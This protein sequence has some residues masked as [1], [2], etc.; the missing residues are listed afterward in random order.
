MNEWII[1][2]VSCFGLGMMTT[3]HPCPL[4]TNLAAISLLN[5]WFQRKRSLFVITFLF[6]G[7]YLSS[8]LLIGIIL[9]TGL[10]NIPTL[11]FAFQKIITTLLGPF[12]ILVGMLLAD[13]IG[14][15]TQYRSRML[16]WVERRG[17]QGFQA[18][19]MG[20]LL[21]LSFCPATAAIFF[22][23]LIPLAIQHGEVVL[24]PILYALGVSLPLIGLSIL[25][26]R[27]GTKLLNERWQAQIPVFA[28]WA[29]ILI[30]IY[31]TIRNI[32]LVG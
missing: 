14:R 7:G 20:A 29:L 25:I 22:G 6:I 12:L 4:A 11:S 9:S 23:L 28:G 32:Y 24:F 8:Y 18:F 27:G 26:R 19:P 30:G 31:M 5:G 21:A 17:S 2:A 3:L 10:L 13:L 15:S 1:A 16:K